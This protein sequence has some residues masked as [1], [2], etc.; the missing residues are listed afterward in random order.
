MQ[1]R[2]N[3]YNGFAIFFMFIGILLFIL[4]NPIN[5]TYSRYANL[6]FGEMAY[7]GEETVSISGIDVIF[8]WKY[9][10]KLYSDLN[11][12]AIIAILFT[13]FS[14]ILTFLV[15]RKKLKEN[16]LT[17]C[18]L[19]L[20]TSSI[21]VLLSTHFFPLNIE[22][23]EDFSLSIMGIISGCSLLLS[24]FCLTCSRWLITENNPKV[25]NSE[26]SKIED[27]E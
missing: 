1:S 17:I 7:I 26:Q 2:K 18:V 24:T 15:T 5:Y 22:N 13:L 27:N 4:G 14:I 8:G 21:F 20:L 23:K 19:L 25:E 6:P 12:Y 11:P 16:I 9:S 10:S 3:N